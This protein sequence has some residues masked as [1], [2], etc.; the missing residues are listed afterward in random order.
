MSIPLNA[1][2][3]NALDEHGNTP[4]ATVH[5]VTGK[6]F[7]VVSAEQFERLKPLF[8]DVPK[9]LDE[10][11][12]ELQQMGKLAGWDDPSMDVYDNYDDNRK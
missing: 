11:R 1:D 2:I 8:D 7:F 3:A 12:F 4:L 10:Q 5:P 9:T 6:V